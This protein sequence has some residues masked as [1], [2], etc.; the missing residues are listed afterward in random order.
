MVPLIS[1]FVIL[2][3]SP[4]GFQSQNGQNYLHSV[5]TYMLHVSIFIQIIMVPFFFQNEEMFNNFEE[6]NRM[7]ICV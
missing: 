3:T 7:T 4:L 2:V 5:E 1:Y 6:F